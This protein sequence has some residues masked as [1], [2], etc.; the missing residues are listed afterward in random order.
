[1]LIVMNKG[2][3]EEHPN[4][5]LQPNNEQL[6]KAVSFLTG[7]NGIFNVTSKNIKLF[8]LKAN[9]DK[10]GYIQI[11][12]PPTAYDIKSLNTEIQRIIFEEEVFTEADYPFTTRPNFSKLGSNIERSSRRPQITFL[13]DDSIRNLFG[14]N[15]TTIYEEQKTYHLIPFFHL[16]KFSSNQI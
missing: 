9:T 15:A 13:P 7:Y 2:T 11:T 1:M 6:K 12:T 4:Q 14:F 3:H 10:D 8:F 5:P 16:I